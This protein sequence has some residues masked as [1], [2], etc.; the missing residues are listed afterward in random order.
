M[1]ADGSVIDAWGLKYHS[2]D[3]IRVADLTKKFRADI[4]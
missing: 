3:V 1:F 2:G 4:P